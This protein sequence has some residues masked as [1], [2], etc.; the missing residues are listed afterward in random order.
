[1][2]D[3]F[4]AF[5]RTAPNF[6]EDHFECR[7]NGY[8]RSDIIQ[9]AWEGWQ[10]ATALQAERVAQFEADAARLDWLD[11]TN[12]RFRMGWNVGQAPAGNV[13]VDTVI[14]L[15]K[16]PV[17]IRAAIDAARAATPQGEKK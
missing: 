12:A 3:D 6:N 9:S 10:A 11:A 14:F 2:R 13:S 4:E 15:G 8:Y 5:L 17:T 7:Q 1:M 16:P